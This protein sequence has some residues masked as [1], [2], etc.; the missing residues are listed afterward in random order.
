[1]WRARLSV[2][3]APSLAHVPLV[4]ILALPMMTIF[5]DGKL[6]S[7]IYKI[8]NIHTETYLDIELHSRNV[9]CRPT[10]NLGEGRGLV[11]WHLTSVIHV[12]DD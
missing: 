4:V 3:Q 12:S 8:Q 10:E 1:M 9:C 5:E 11:R 7:G 2:I 6:K